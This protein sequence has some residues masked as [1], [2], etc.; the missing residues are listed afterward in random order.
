VQRILVTHPLVAGGLDALAGRYEVVVAGGLER[1]EELRAAVAGFDALIPSVC[2]R[3]TAA[4]LEAADRLRVVANCGVG[5]DNVDVAAARARGVVVTNTP[6]VL[7][8]ATADLTWAALLAVVRRVV[9]GDALVR[10]GRFQGFGPTLL[11]GVDLAGKTLGVVGLG[12]IGRAVARRA[13]GF[14]LRV[15]FADPAAPG[16][17]DVGAGVLARGL[18]LEQLLAEADLV[19]LHVPLT[20]ET[21]HLLDARRLA[22][23]RRGAYLINTSRGPVIDEAALALRL[24]GGHLAGAA[25]DVYEHEPRLA[26][27]LTGLPNVV[28]LPHI[29]SATVETRRRMAQMA[30]ANAD[31]VLQGRAPPNRVGEAAG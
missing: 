5:Y 25:L 3:V 8:E 16:E 11:L 14:G 26:E 30:A 23:L 29:G 20:P 7:T 4:V 28:L 27:G 19:S 17:V 12:Q 9:E 6:G 18:P 13:A 2:A 10:S 15:V 24:A 1:P 31:A 22:L 21:R